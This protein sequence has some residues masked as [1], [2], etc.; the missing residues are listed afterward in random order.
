[1]SPDTSDLP[2]DIDN[3]YRQIKQ[4]VANDMGVLSSAGMRLILEAII[5]E[6]AIPGTDLQNKINNMA[7]ALVAQNHIP[8][9]QKIRLYGNDAIHD[10]KA[11]R[12]SDIDSALM[13]IENLL[14]NVYILP[15]KLGKLHIAPPNWTAIN[16]LNGNVISDGD[17]DKLKDAIKTHL[18][19]GKLDASVNKSA[20]KD[21]ARIIFSLCGSVNLFDWQRQFIQK[22][23]ETYINQSDEQA[24]RET[25]QIRVQ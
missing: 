11:L 9:L 18:N 21:L 2:T 3:V 10:L 7:P 24:S 6:K 1:M 19:G 5:K 14:Y 23:L 20:T 16:A 25:E 13:V 15:A 4:A 8:I 12:R 17:L 22:I